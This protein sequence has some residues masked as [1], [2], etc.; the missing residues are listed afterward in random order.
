MADNERILENLK[1]TLC[2]MIEIIDFETKYDKKYVKEL[3]NDV[4]K[5]IDLLDELE[6]YRAIGT[7]EEFKALKEKSVAKKPK[8]ERGIYTQCVCGNVFSRLHK[9][10]YYYVPYENKTKY[11]PKCGQRLDWE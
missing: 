6:E 11:C 9:D 8:K 1:A 2:D 5:I 7:V 4:S 3:D 10:Y